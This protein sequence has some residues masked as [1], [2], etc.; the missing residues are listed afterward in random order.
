M[1]FK[2]KVILV[3]FLNNK[4]EIEFLISFLCGTKIETIKI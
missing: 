2:L 3:F 1:L 4:L